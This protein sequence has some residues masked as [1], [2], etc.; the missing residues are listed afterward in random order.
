MGFLSLKASFHRDPH[1]STW[2]A[3][4][5]TPS[6]P[7]RRPSFKLHVCRNSKLKLESRD[8]SERESDGREER[9]SVR[10]EVTRLVFR[11]SSENIRPP[12]SQE[13]G[14]GKDKEKVIAAADVGKGIVLKFDRLNHEKA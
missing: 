9:P 13:K 6:A 10:P 1:G 7:S 12:S 11:E 2:N 5:P 4:T 3:P 8:P 14:K